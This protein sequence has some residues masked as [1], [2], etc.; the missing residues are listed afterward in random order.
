M[1]ITCTKLFQRDE[2][3]DWPVADYSSMNSSAADLTGV[4]CKVVWSPTQPISPVESIVEE[5]YISPPT[6]DLKTLSPGVN[7]VEAQP[8]QQ[9]IENQKS[10]VDRK[11]SH[12]Q[13]NESYEEQEQENVDANANPKLP[14]TTGSMALV[15]CQNFKNEICELHGTNLVGV[16]SQISA[17]LV[18]VNSA[19]LALTP[20]TK[21]L[22]L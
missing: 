16:N 7:L 21:A 10:E 1:G 20:S 14:A 12:D 2:E 5:Q 19:P 4:V 11:R 15:P 6:I 18:G 8:R 3:E 13:L 22:V 9:I 17:D